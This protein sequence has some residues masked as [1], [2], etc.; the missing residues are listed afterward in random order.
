MSLSETVLKYV[1]WLAP[2]RAKL[3][4]AESLR[5]VPVRSREVKW[6][7]KGSPAEEGAVDPEVVPDGLIILEVPRRDDPVGRAIS[8]VFQITGT[9]SIELD[10]FGSEIW[11]M[12]DGAH[13]VQHMVART[14]KTYRLNERQAEVSVVAFMRMLTSRRLIG[15]VEEGKS[16]VTSRG[17]SSRTGTGKSARST[18]NR[19]P[20][21]RRRH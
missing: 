16:I 12:C 17:T 13:K 1:P 9:K 20:A 10:E 5:L 3:T 14:V 15:F 4:R 11:R 19:A 6:R 18:G 7:A 2:G 8:A 21:R